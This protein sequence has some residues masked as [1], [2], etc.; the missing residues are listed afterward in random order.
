MSSIIK[1]SNLLYR[2]D[3]PIKVS[4]L[5]SNQMQIAKDVNHNQEANSNVEELL[6]NKL[7]EL[8]KNIEEAE[9][10]YKKIIE[11]SNELI[12]KTNEEVVKLKNEAREEG[13]NSGFQEGISKAND[14]FEIMKKRLYEEVENEKNNN[15]ISLNSEK[16]N[17]LITAKEK[18]TNIIEITLSQV[19]KYEIKHN[20]TFLNTLVLKGLDELGDEKEIRILLSEEDYKVFDKEDFLNALKNDYEEVKISISCDKKLDLGD[21]IIE[22]SAGFINVG[23]NNIAQYIAFIIDKN[24]SVIE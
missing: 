2:S 10:S 20:K 4:S 7:E 22:T 1:H 9:K 8:S 6:V 18:I 3:E 24:I 5:S 11:E 21:S 12:I 13:Y 16:H 17:F 19:L 15:V 14:E 23:V